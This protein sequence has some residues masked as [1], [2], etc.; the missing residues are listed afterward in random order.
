MIVSWNG[1]SNPPNGKNLKG[2]LLNKINPEYFVNQ[3]VDDAA[4]KELGVVSHSSASAAGGPGLA[5]AANAAGFLDLE[6]DIAQ[7]NARILE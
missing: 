7:Y 6:S 4:I 2:E 5:R 1:K 3:V